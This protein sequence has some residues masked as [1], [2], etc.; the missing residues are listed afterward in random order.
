M[1]STPP[2]EPLM[3]PVVLAATAELLRVRLEEMDDDDPDDPA[4]DATYDRIDDVWQTLD[5]VQLRQVTFNMATLAA[6][7]LL[8]AMPEV[9]RDPLEIV[10]G[11]LDQI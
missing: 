5:D 6:A 2:A 9:G 1:T 4:V 7:L 10:A 3:D 8:R 11:I